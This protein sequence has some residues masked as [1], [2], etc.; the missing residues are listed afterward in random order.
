M[1][2]EVSIMLEVERWIVPL[3]LANPEVSTGSS[4]LTTAKCPWPDAS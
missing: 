2:E 4:H 1:G 3:A